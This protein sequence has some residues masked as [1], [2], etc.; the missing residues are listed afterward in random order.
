MSTPNANMHNHDHSLGFFNYLDKSTESSLYRNGKVLIRRDTGG[1]DSEMQGVVHD[2]QEK[3]V[4]NGRVFS[5]NQGLSLATNGFELLTRPLAQPGLDFL[6]QQQVV[7]Y[8]YPECARIIEEATGGRAFSF[9]HNVR[10]VLGKQSGKQISGGQQVQE[11]LHLVHGDYT[12]TSAPQR[13]RDLTNPPGSN[14]TLRS[15]LGDNES[16]ISNETVERALAGGGRFAIIN[17]WRNISSEPVATHPLALCDSQTVN[18]EDLVVFEIHY[19]DRLGEN[20]FAKHAERH[21]WY[22]FPE[23]TGDE[24]LLIK[25]WD[26]AGPLARSDGK[27]ADASDPQSPSTFS[28]HSA[29]EDPATPYGAPDR[30]SIE[31][32]CIVFYD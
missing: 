19:Q 5:G 9:D 23:M 31:V 18:P 10:S 8:Y 28:F 25:Q 26:S 2:K 29:F 7:Q 3:K 17:L 16:L 11:P 30:Q 32:R 27:Q 22:Y 14:D 4:H 12:L 21:H 20:Y 15:V 1:N 24:A 13:L 6:D